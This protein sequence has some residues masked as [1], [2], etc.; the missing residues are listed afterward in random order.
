MGTLCPTQIWWYLYVFLN[1]LTIL[2]V[3]LYCSIPVLSPWSNMAEY[4]NKCTMCRKKVQ[5]FSITI[6]C[7]NCHVVY[8]IK[9]VNLE[10]DEA[11]TIQFWYCSFCLEDVFAFNHL[12][13]DDEYHSAL[14]ENIVDHSYQFLEIDKKIFNPFEMNNRID[15]PLTVYQ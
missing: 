6:C 1:I 4:N 13:D 14:K 8:H 2:H 10:R 5:S 9:C 7:T 12:I 11:A 3:P 15:T